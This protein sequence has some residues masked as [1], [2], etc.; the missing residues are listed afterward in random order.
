MIRPPRLVIEKI[1]LGKSA[2]VEDA[3]LRTDRR[4]IERRHLTAI[5][6][7]G[8]L[9]KPRHVRP[10]GVVGPRL[11]R[12]RAPVGLVHVVSRQVLMGAVLNV[13]PACGESTRVFRGHGRFVWKLTVN[14]VVAP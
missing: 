11:L 8:P 6:K 7:A 14:L 1:V 4:P 9:E 2:S 3:E 10:P 5:I 13:N 12:L